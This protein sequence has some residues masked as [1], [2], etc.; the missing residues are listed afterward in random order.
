MSGKPPDPMRV[1]P[2]QLSK[3]QL[4]VCF[5]ILRERMRHQEAELTNL[6]RRP[7][8]RIVTTIFASLLMLLSGLLSAYGINKLTGVPPDPGAISL[9]YLAVA[10][11]FISLVLQIINAGV[12]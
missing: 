4:T 12:R 8:G 3:E 2:S 1:D 5:E 6:K 9:V 7:F 10:I 11:Y